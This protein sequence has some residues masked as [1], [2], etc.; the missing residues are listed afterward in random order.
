MFLTLYK[1]KTGYTGFIHQESA[2]KI[3]FDLHKPHI[4]LVG[5]HDVIH[6]FH[7]LLRKGKTNS[8]QTLVTETD[9][10]IHSIRT[11]YD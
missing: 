4:T 6:N 3:S 5:I 10:N 8:I 11:V 1:G 7:I 2:I 9:W